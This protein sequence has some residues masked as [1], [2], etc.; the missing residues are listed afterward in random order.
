MPHPAQQRFPMTHIVRWLA[1]PALVLLLPGA[2]REAEGDPIRGFT[3]ASSSVEREWERKFRAIPDPSRTR[4]AMRR[5]SARP[6][7]VGSAYAKA[8]AEWLRA[9]SAAY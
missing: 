9:Q 5:L 6:H 4:E 8:N 2:A 7:P 3:A 1:V